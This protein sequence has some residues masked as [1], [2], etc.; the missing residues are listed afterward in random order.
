MYETIFEQKNL[1]EVFLQSGYYKHAIPRLDFATDGTDRFALKYQQ[2]GVTKKKADE[3]NKITVFNSRNLS[4]FFTQ[5]DS[6]VTNL[7]SPQNVVDEWRVIKTSDTNYSVSN[8][9]AEIHA[10][11]P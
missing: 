1:W 6:Y 4:E 10:K 3:S 9:T 2:L 11:Y 8:N 7:F 5:Y